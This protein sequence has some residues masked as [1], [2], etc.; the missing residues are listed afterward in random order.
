MMPALAAPLAAASFFLT[1]HLLL[2]PENVIWGFSVMIWL[3]F[4]AV[5]LPTHLY[6]RDKE[7]GA[8]EFLFSKPLDRFRLWWIKL[9]IGVAALVVGR[10]VIGSFFRFFWKRWPIMAEVAECG[11]RHV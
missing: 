1:R 4:A 3:A 11:Q 9:F 2:H 5:Y 10:A 8:T 7:I 6:T